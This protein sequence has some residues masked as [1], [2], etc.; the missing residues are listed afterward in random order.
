MHGVRG[1]REML[2][3]ENVSLKPYNPPLSM[4]LTAP[5]SNIF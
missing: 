3:Q 2:A 1:A 4:G 5:V